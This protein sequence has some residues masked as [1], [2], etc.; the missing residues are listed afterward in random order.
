[1]RRKDLKKNY[2]ID[3]D[4][5]DKAKSY[6]SGELRASLQEDLQLRDRLKKEFEQVC[7]EQNPGS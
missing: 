2:E 6:L 3:L 5:V 1:M 4:N 7:A